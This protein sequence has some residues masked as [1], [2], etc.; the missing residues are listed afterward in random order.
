M[1]TEPEQGTARTTVG[2]ISK[3]GTIIHSLS[4]F[5][6]V[7]GMDFYIQL[8]C[9]ARL[10]EFYAVVGLEIFKLLAL[11]TGVF[12]GSDQTLDMNDRYHTFLNDLL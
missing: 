3:P 7:V 5:K 6:Q 9:G 10:L 8:S 4:A 12:F 2:L 1:V 11:N